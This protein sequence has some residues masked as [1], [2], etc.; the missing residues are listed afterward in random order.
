[1]SVALSP[2]MQHY[3]QTKEQYKDALL[4]YRLGDFYELFFDDALTAS[5]AL[6]L[7]LTGR[8]CG[9]EERAPMCGVPAKSVDVYI[10]KLIELGY[11]VA[12]CEQLTE[13]T[14]GQMVDRDVVRVVTPGTIMESNIL[15]E[16]KNN[17]IASV[18]LEKQNIGLAFTD[19]STGE[20]YV[21]EFT[22]E[23]SLKQLNDILVMVRPSEIICNDEM[24]LNSYNLEGVKLEV[25]PKFFAY[26]N[27]AYEKQKA[28]NNLKQQFKTQ[29]LQVF[30]LSEKQFAT[31]ASGALI[32]YLNET[33]K[34]SL[35]H[36]NKITH[37]K[38]NYFMYLDVNTRKNLELT[39]T[40]RD[41][42]KTGSLLWLLD[43]T[44]TSMGARMLRS[45]VEQPLQDE[46][47]INDRL[48]GVEEIASNTILRQ[49]LIEEL[50]NINDI[51]RLAGKIS[52]GTL[53]PR[54]CLS[55]LVSLKQL[56]NIK[57]LLQQVNSSILKNITRNL[58]EFDATVLLLENA[59]VDNPPLT[60][61]DGGYIK[62]GYNSELDELKSSNIEGKK[63]IAKLEA[64]EKEATGIKNLKIGFNRVFGYYLEVTNSQKELVPF[65][66][67]RKQTLTGGERYITEELKQIE[68]KILNSEEKSLKLELQLFQEIRETL[69]EQVEHLQTSAKQI[70]LL[71]TLCSFAEVS[72]KNNY[73]KPQI[74]N[75]IT[76]IEIKDG[77]H[78]VIEKLLKDENFVPNDTHLDTLDNRTMIITGP[79]MAGKSTYMRQVAII[80]LMAHLGC[81]VPATS[82]KIALTDRIFTRIGASDDLINNQSTFMVEMVEVANILHSATNK[83]LIILDEIG[84]GTSTFDGL[85]IAWSVM[86]YVSKHL[87]AKTLFST[88]YHELT[89]LE[90]S[91]EGIKNYRINVKEL[92]GTILFLRKIARGG[93]LKSF[94]IEV[95]SLAGLPKEVTDRAKQIL[96]KLEEA[97]INKAQRNYELEKQENKSVITK[98]Q[99][100]VIRLLK[101]SNIENLSPLE[102]FSI[103]QEL[104]EK[105]KKA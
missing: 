33:Q 80:T 92:N 99:D 55:L 75:R 6:D 93:A 5:K 24:F 42:K 39:E 41:R 95:A 30:D 54:D 23:Q 71:D 53:S 7:T 61:K 94:G 25:L 59:I 87:N 86:E 104:I 37:L 44:K 97:D 96:Q 43:Q 45:F 83:S 73:V 89:E 1:M 3:L 57:K 10:A 9:L 20:F 79:N 22:K 76:E 27:W 64:E 78:P 91:L 66:Y 16:K 98:Y 29:S 102:A 26:F 17:Y 84:R 101:Q 15:D 69:L 38:D 90:G 11:K 103:L 82:A 48:N 81:F 65:R 19:I 77:R 51:E 14:K 2:M 4:F 100:E 52:Y 60:T 32:E 35:M 70:A 47:A 40:I 85:S 88:H 21:T 12:I 49:A 8:A 68:D 34:R 63:W 18:I 62:K 50:N 46:T 56:P 72:V 13:A 58:G 31:R 105:V 36:I 28:Q 67:Q 74:N